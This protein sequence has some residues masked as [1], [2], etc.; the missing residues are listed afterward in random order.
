MQPPETML[1][2]KEPAMR[3][4]SMRGTP[5]LRD[6]PPGSPAR[7][8]QRLSPRSLTPPPDLDIGGR[9]LDGYAM[10][11]RLS[12]EPLCF[13]RKRSSSFRS[14]GS[15]SA[16]GRE[17]EVELQE[18]DST[19]SDPLMSHDLSSV[20]KKT[21]SD[22]SDEAIMIGELLSRVDGTSKGQS[23][24]KKE[25]EETDKLKEGGSHD[26]QVTVGSTPPAK[27]SQ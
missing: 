13:P 17:E 26:S 24:K 16:S 15:V 2:V 22:E 20:N 12:H 27:T 14:S 6:T 25:E 5:P 3:D 21:C 11:S 8:F 1:V 19:V 10:D 4:P 18:A 9:N 7:V 23:A